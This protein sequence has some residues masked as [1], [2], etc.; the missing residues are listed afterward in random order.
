M[1]SYHM[2]CYV[3]NW[4]IDLPS[5]SIINQKNGEQKRLGE[6]QLKLL[7]VLTQYAGKVITRE[8]LTALVWEK[9]IIG[10]NSLPNAIHALRIALEDDG[11]DQRI[12]KTIPKRGYLLEKEFCLFVEVEHDAD[13]FLLQELSYDHPDSTA[14][15]SF[16]TALAT[17]S[18]A[19]DAI[20]NHNPDNSF[21]NDRFDN[22][23]SDNDN[24][25]NNRFDNDGFT[26]D[27]L[28][29]DSS[30]NHSLSTHRL[31]DANDTNNNKINV[32]P[33]LNSDTA[34]IE[35]QTQVKVAPQPVTVNTKTK[36]HTSFLSPLFYLLLLTGIIFAGFS[37][38]FISKKLESLNS[39][40]IQTQHSNMLSR[41]KIYQIVRPQGVED[42]GVIEH[43]QQRIDTA[44]Q[45]L[46]QQLV[47]QDANMSIYY[48][49]LAS[50]LN[51]TFSISNFCNK[52]ELSM[53]I[54]HWRLNSSRLNDLIYRET[55]RK[56]NELAPC[57]S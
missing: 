10:N 26:N 36:H 18:T 43:I 13:E 35:D 8:R 20:F 31:N 50:T 22:D 21:D 49:T 5:G 37:A 12:I 51:Y 39:Y 3:N 32:T 46:N 48:S 23:R 2:R 55:A 52:Q 53:T 19:T 29:N 40:T 9:R 38:Y 41:I 45:R 33:Q 42:Q 14:N 54:Y 47:K 24:F 15:T 56:L 44:L 6:Y 25:D 34:L 1:N 30:N 11:K 57:S 16:K 4:L 27:Q 17:I 28:D 7:D